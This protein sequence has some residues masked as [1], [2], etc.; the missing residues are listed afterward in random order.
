MSHTRTSIL[1]HL[2]SAKPRIPRLRDLVAE[3]VQEYMLIQFQESPLLD[4]E[5][6]AYPRGI[7]EAIAGVDQ[8]SVVLAWLF[9]E[10]SR[11]EDQ[12]PV[13]TKLH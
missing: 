11:Y 2:R 8:A 1:L 5:R 3:L 10:T 4:G 9:G 6:R 13:P 7:Q 12:S